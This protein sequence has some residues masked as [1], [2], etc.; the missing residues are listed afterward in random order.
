[1]RGVRV[2]EQ[3]RVGG[4]LLVGREV[5]MAPGLG[6]VLHDHCHP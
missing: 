1:M 2:V 3:A 4:K 5:E 6:P